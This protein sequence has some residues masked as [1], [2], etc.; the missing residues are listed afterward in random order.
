M[1]EVR[2]PTGSVLT[3]EIAGEAATVRDQWAPPGHR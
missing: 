2:V 3:L 1:H